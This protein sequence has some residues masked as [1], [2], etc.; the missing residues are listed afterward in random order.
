MI[1]DII[2][3]GGT[4]YYSAKKLKEMGFSAV[5][6]YASHVE[7]SLHNEEKGTLIKLINNGVIDELFTTNSI[8]HRGNSERITVIDDF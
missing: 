1:D 3:Y 2:S 8:Y 6:A 4:L 5:Y 7:D